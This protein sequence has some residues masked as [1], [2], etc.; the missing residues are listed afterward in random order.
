MKPCQRALVNSSCSI[1]EISEACGYSSMG[2]L[3]RAFKH[4]NGVTPTEYRK[5]NKLY[6]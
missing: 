3:C 1:A 2:M 6:I 4:K 5:E